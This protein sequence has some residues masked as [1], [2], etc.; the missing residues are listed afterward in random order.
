MS[1]EK[2]IKFLEKNPDKFFTTVEIAKKTNQLRHNVN[3]N[4]QAM[5][6]FGEIR[7]KT[8]II[9]RT[10]EQYSYACIQGVENDDKE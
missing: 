10:Q 6:K 5:V 2:T 1:Q 9:G 7:K 4:C 3:R 8:K